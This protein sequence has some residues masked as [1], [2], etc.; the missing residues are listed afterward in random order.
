MSLYRLVYYSENRILASSANVQAEVDQILAQSR[1][2]NEMVGVTGA[3]MFSS[4][5][6]GQVLEGPQAAVEATFERIQQDP[7]HGDVA[8]LEFVPTASRSF[9]SWAMAFVG[10]DPD[11]F[12]H[13]ASETGFDANKI[14]GQALF[15]KLRSMVASNAVFA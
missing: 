13:L 6:F 12:A 5:Y 8:L 11:I 1:R 9:D 7:R 4:G 14:T 2:N 3:L 10:Q 15:S